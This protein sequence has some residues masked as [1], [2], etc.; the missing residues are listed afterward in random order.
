MYRTEGDMLGEQ[1]GKEGKLDN[2]YEKEGG[3][4][5]NSG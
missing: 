1:E 4:T 3:E 2:K 5:E